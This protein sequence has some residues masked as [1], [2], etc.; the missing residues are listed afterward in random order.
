MT[1]Y[2]SQ[3]Q[4]HRPASIEVSQFYGNRHNLSDIFTITVPRSSQ[5]TPRMIGDTGTIRL[6]D[7]AKAYKFVEA[8]RNLLLGVWENGEDEGNDVAWK[9]Y[10]Y[11]V[12]IV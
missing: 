7:L 12:R 11:I 1:V 9:Y 5:D 6:Q 4:D 3:K 8:N 10:K 2:I